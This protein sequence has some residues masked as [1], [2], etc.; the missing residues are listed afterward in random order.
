MQSQSSQWKKAQDQHSMYNAAKVFYPRAV[1]V[2]RDLG[3][4]VLKICEIS[5]HVIDAFYCTNSWQIYEHNTC[6][7]YYFAFNYFTILILKL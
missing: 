2:T 1:F 6:V 5:Y 4:V 7:Q 3:F